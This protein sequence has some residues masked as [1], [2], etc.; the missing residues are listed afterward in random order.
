MKCAARRV[1]ARWPGPLTQGNQP[2]SF[3]ACFRPPRRTPNRCGALS[4]APCGMPRAPQWVYRR[5]QRRA[6]QGTELAPSLSV[7]RCVYLRAPQRAAQG[8]MPLSAH[9]TASRAGRRL[10]YFSSL[11]GSRASFRSASR[12]VPPNDSRLEP[13][14]FVV[15]GTGSACSRGRSSVLAHSLAAVTQG[16]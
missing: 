15:G 10:G 14:S 3:V 8:S 16:R 12:G 4:I 1:F 13:S 6:A 5:E 9:I 2:A 11:F 7:A